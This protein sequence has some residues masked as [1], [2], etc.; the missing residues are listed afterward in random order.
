MDQNVLVGSGHAL[1]RALELLQ[2]SRTQ[3]DLLRIAS[4]TPQDKAAD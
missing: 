1:V 4:A 2:K 3:K